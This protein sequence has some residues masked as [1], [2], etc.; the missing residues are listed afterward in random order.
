M[1]RMRKYSEDL[2]KLCRKMYGKG[3]GRRDIY[4]NYVVVRMRRIRQNKKNAVR[5]LRLTLPS[6]MSSPYTTI[7]NEFES[8][9][10]VKTASYYR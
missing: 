10:K 3:F 8:S 7:G 6:P 4:W 9:C 2:F 5:E 1:I